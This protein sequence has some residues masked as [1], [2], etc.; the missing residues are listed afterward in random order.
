MNDHD[1]LH[2][3]AGAHV[4]GA[5]DASERAEFEAHLATCERCRTEVAS[6]APIPGLLTR[7]EQG[8]D[9]PIP[10]DLV[11]AVAASAGA[12]WHAVVRS[13]RR[14]RWTA[15]AAVAVSVAL[16]VGSLWT[17]GPAK[18]DLVLAVGSGS[19]SGE[20]TIDARTW[21]SAIEF[22]LDGLPP[23]DRYVAWVL[24]SDGTRQQSATWGP[25]PAG[26]ARLAGAAQ[27]AAAEVAGIEITDGSGTEIIAT[28]AG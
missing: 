20:V 21:G 15:V 19:V 12:Q 11:D 16:V 8:T 9:V 22:E 26:R 17:S 4:L 23:R 2:E 28:T 14:W 25:T 7:A 10:Q 1:R 27:I 6:F 13:R 3:M 18:P 24:G 5:L